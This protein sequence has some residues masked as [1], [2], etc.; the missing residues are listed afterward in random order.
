M[1][2][3]SAGMDW[4]PILDQYLMWEMV[5]VLVLAVAVCSSLGMSLGALAGLIPE[6][7]VSV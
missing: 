6:E 1:V 3:S 5:P 4:L 2:G 7:S